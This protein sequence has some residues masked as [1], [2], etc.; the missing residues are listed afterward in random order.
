[1]IERRDLEERIARCRKDKQLDK[2][3]A[4]ALTT[5]NSVWQTWFNLMGW[6]SIVAMAIAAARGRVAVWIGLLLIA[7]VFFLVGRLNTPVGERVRA[8]LLK[9][10]KLTRAAFVAVN[11]RWFREGN[12]DAYPGFVLISLDA[13]LAA[14][15]QRFRSVVEALY[16]IRNAD[17]SQMDP[18]LAA[19]AWAFYHE[20]NTRT[21]RVRVPDGFAGAS[22]T[23]LCGTMFP[24]GTALDEDGCVW[25]LALPD[26]DD[27]EAVAVLPRSLLVSG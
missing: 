6:V 19:L 14:D 16:E 25:V 21:A 2:R 24:P 11:D 5:S 10:G 20:M 22:E 13:T 12:T 4:K 7:S 26:E 18:G 23:W 3:L 9:Q 27:M 15:S 1:V 8:K 17:R